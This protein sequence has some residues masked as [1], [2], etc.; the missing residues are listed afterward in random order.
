[1]LRKMTKDEHPI[2]EFWF[3][4]IG[5]EGEIDE[6]KQARWW[7]KSSDFDALCREHFEEELRAVKRGERDEL[8]KTPRGQ[9]SY[10]LLC[11]QMPRNMFRDTPEAFAWDSLALAATMELIESGDLLKL[12]PRVQA[13]ALMPLMHSEDAE[14]Q[15]QS[16]KSFTELKERGVDNCDFA[17]SHKKI[18][19]RFGRYP[20][21]NKILGR[22]STEE[23]IEFLKGPGSSF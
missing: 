22:T 13:F 23:E 14:V 12:H 3:G 11:D 4:D 15:V 1:M 19:D 18:I 5:S 16:L 9:V 8:K 17:I 7:K 10:I 20:H 21:R 2:F 6:A